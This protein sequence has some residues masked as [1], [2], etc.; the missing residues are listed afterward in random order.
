MIPG[1]GP[2]WTGRVEIVEEHLRDPIRWQKPRRVF[3]N[4][5]SDLFHESLPDEAIARVFDV[6]QE[7]RQHTFQVLTKRARRLRDYMRAP[8]R[9]SST[10]VWPPTNVWLGVSV[11]D[12]KAAAERLPFLTETPAAVRVVSY[13]PALEGVDFSPWAGA[14][15]WIIVGA[16]SGPGARPFSA[17]WARDVIE[18]GFRAGVFVFVKQLGRASYP[19]LKDPKG[20]DPME[21]PESLR[22]REFPPLRPRINP[23]IIHRDGEGF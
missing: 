12:R 16:E 8:W 13:E 2:R 6:M 5:M 9:D 19:D 21:W 22:I 3:V 4:S 18:L 17:T 23:A 7:A 10:S 15:D 11:E 14:L 1:V 20:G